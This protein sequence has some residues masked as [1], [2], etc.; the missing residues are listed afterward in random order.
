ML[1][2]KL[3]R[4]EQRVKEASELITQLRSEKEELENK[5]RETAKRNQELQSEM[6]YLKSIQDQFGLR[7]ESI[8]SHLD[9]VSDG[10]MTDAIA[11]YEKKIQ[12]NANDYQACFNLGNIFEKKGFFDKAIEVYRKAIKIKPDF[13]SAIEHLAFLLEKLN[14]EH[15]ASPLWDKVLALKK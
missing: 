4:L 6:D 5:Y 10:T 14:R 3:D 8:C 1:K 11:V 7:L 13:V 12:H 9:T 15:E 2:E